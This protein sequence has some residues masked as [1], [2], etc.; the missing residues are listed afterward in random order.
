[1][2]FSMYNRHSTARLQWSAP[3]AL[4]EFFF[5]IPGMCLSKGLS[6]GV[7]V[8]WVAHILSEVF[9]WTPFP[10]IVVFPQSAIPTQTMFTVQCFHKWQYVVA[11][12]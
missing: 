9:D 11:P 12:K 8:Q 6:C 1:M 3:C 2:I 7:G 4:L 10:Y 5:D